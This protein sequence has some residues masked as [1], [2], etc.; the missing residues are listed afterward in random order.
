MWPP[1]AASAASHNLDACRPDEGRSG[2]TLLLLDLVQEHLPHGGV[3]GLGEESGGVQPGGGSRALDICDVSG[4]W[5]MREK[6]RMARTLDSPRADQSDPLVTLS[7]H[8]VSINSNRV[9]YSGMRDS[10]HRAIARLRRL[11]HSR[12]LPCTPFY[13]FPTPTPPS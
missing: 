11:R 7:L 10:V 1:A 8:H 6:E 3:L 2:A 13:L 9:E 5:R 4:G 12:P